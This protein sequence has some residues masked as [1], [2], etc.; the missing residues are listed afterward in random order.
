MENFTLP[1]SNYCPSLL[2]YCP[3]FSDFINSTVSEVHLV[4]IGFANKF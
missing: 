1:S 3:Y 4:Y 2:F